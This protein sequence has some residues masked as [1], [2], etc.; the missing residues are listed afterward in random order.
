MNY[1]R[2]ISFIDW[3]RSVIAFLLVCASQILS[4]GNLLPNGDCEALT[5][6]NGFARPA[7]IGSGQHKGSQG[8]WGT[9]SQILHGGKAAAFLEKTNQPGWCDMAFTTPAFA[10]LEETREVEIKLWLKA[11][12]CRTGQIV[13]TGAD[14]TRQQALWKALYTYRGTFDWTER[15]IHALIPAGIR[16][17]TLS[18]RLANA[19]AKL[20]VDDVTLAWVDSD[21]PLLYNADFESGAQPDKNLPVGWEEREF[22]GYEAN[23][24]ITLTQGQA[25]RNAVQI[26]WVSGG[27]KFGV[28]SPLLRTFQAKNLACAVMFRSDGK[29][30][31]GC[32]V[33]FFDQG[34][35]LLGST[36]SPSFQPVKAKQWS[37]QTFPFALPENAM[38]IRLVLLLGG[39]G[40]VCYDNVRFLEGREAMLATF[41]LEATCRSIDTALVWNNGQPVFHTFADSP[42]SFTISFKGDK[43]KLK[44]PTLVVDIP[45][46][47]EVAQCFESHTDFGTEVPAEATPTARDGVPYTRYRFSKAHVWEQIQHGW[48]WHRDLTM[49]F[50]PKQPMSDQRAGQ[51]YWH[52]E[53][54]GVADDERVFML[55]VL[56][57]LSDLPLPKRLRGG[58]WNCHTYDF[59]NREIFLKAIRHLE[60]CGMNSRKRSASRREFDS[61][62]KTRGWKMATSVP[63]IDYGL[64]FGV[65]KDIP[66]GDKIDGKIPPRI[67]DGKPD[68][69]K[70]CPEYFLHDADYAT[71][72]RNY[73]QNSVKKR[74]YEPGENLTLDTEPWSP[75]KWCHCER[76]RHAFAQF[77]GWQ[78]LPTMQRILKEALDEWI[79]FRCQQVVDTFARYHEYI[80]ETFPTAI[81]LDYDY[82]LPFHDQNAL[83]VHL[84]GVA[85]DSSRTEQYFDAHIQSM[86]HLF[87]APGF[88]YV[89]VN[90]RVLK[91]DYQVILAIDPPGSYLQPRNTEGHGSPRQTGGGL[92]HPRNR[93]PGGGR[94]CGHGLPKGQ[95]SP[96]CRP[97]AA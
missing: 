39:E 5:E 37:L 73:L 91:K 60:Q 53:N 18:V 71:F 61:F 19:P 63:C 46:W 68:T 30:P 2:R 93:Q 90:R 70:L 13:L 77:A 80:R 74:G 56:P 87:N 52:L 47:L 17:L 86:Y 83:R 12:N 78:E 22:D 38:F 51:A 1:P 27:S 96:L 45:D 40:T 82:L 89:R 10:P 21:R 16:R 66:G 69:H 94:G 11:E 32:L 34:K 4:A 57:P 29:C 55:C 25:S 76:C 26:N 3:K 64:R 9:D 6:Q 8:T 20:W 67:L 75:K 50:L 28:Q 7:H 23:C 97:S 95:S 42:T 79:R 72:A 59:P 36:E 41:P 92:C 49:A 48:A 44:N 85:K 43:G 33:E 31:G 54:D 88:D 58:Y 84:G 81:I 65:P 15:T 35:K 14:N 62:L 24:T